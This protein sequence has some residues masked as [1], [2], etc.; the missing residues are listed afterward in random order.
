MK[1]L[2]EKLLSVSSVTDFIFSAI[3]LVSI[4]AL[5]VYSARTS[6]ELVLESFHPNFNHII[7]KITYII[8]LLKAYRIL[9]FYLKYHN[10]SIKYLVQIAI[11]APAVEVIFAINDQAMWV[12]LLYAGF[13]LANL[14]IYLG[15]YDR[16]NQLDDSDKAEYST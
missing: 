2:R 15:F 4:L 10:L 13:S 5:V 7:H 1:K 8:V 12:N 16:F 3:I 14:V 6:W 9:I 11:I